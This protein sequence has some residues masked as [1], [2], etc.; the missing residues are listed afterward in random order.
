M[1]EMIKILL[2]VILAT[3]FYPTLLDAQM[4]LIPQI[5]VVE[6]PVVSR[7]ADTWEFNVNN[8]GDFCIDSRGIIDSPIIIFKNDTFPYPFSLTTPYLNSVK[9][10]R[11]SRFDEYIFIESFPVGASGL[12]ANVVNVAVIHARKGK[13]I[14]ISSYSSFFGGVELVRKDRSHLAVSIVQYMGRTSQGDLVCVYEF[15]MVSEIWKASKRNVPWSGIY[16]GG[17]TI[18]RK[19][20]VCECP[21]KENPIVH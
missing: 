11:V 12:S 13:E 5:E 17:A 3:C 2:Y 4:V 20:Q 18:V 14:T 1:S 7:E 16:S 19:D 10:H 8:V 6:V 15:N 9:Y 21:I